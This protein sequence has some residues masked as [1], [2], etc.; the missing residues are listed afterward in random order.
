MPGIKLDLIGKVES[1]DTDFIRVLDH[2]RASDQL[3]QASVTH[4]NSS[5]H[6]PWQYY[7][8]S[9]LAEHVYRAYE[10]DFDRFQYPRSR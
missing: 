3:R 4:L 6:S 2:A 9:D 5:Q 7:Y 10:R 8:S 1:F